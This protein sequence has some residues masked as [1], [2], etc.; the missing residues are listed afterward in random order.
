VINGTIVV[1]DSKELPVKPGQEIRFP[2][3][4]KGRFKPVNV[5]GRL[6]EHTIG[7]QPDVFEADMDDTT[8]AGARKRFRP[9]LPGVIGSAAAILINQG[10]QNAF[11]GG[12]SGSCVRK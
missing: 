4:D 3:E 1:K 7:L 5:E 2:V 8:G 12:G 9:F 6:N 10:F 11:F